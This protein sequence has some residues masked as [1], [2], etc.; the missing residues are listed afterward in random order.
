MRRVALAVGRWLVDLAVVTSQAG[1]ALI[2]RGSPDETISARCHRKQH[3][4]RWRTARQVINAVYFWQKDHCAASYAD[5]VER[6]K[7]VT[8]CG[9]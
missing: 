4:P 6:A 9:R 8:M 3:L 2:L 5:D 1:N 7:L